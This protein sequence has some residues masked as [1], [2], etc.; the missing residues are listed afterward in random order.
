MEKY[1]IMAIEKGNTDAMNNLGF[2]HHKIT[3]N[4]DLM[5]KYY[6]MAIE[7]G[8]SKA[9]HNFKYYHDNGK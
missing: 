5:K 4:Y 3:K 2:Y 1:Y 8:H 7:K 9:M 6:M